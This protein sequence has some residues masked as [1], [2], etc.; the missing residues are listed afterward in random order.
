MKLS[1][2]HRV[3]VLQ[4]ERDKLGY[5]LAAAAE[6][7]FNLT[8]D[9]GYHSIDQDLKAVLAPVLTAELRRRIAVIDAELVAL[10]VTIDTADYA[11]LQ[12]I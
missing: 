11:E 5:R 6:H 2:F 7:R 1:D 3:N 10:Q 8:L 12:R 4:A 9:G